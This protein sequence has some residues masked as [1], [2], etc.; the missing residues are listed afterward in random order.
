M[1]LDEIVA[2]VDAGRAVRWANGGYHVIRG[3]TG[4]LLIWCEFNDNCI[5]LTWQD[6]VTL[7]GR[8]EQFYIEDC[9]RR[10]ETA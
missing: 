3:A 5:G 10:K 4:E 1:T 2:A 9:P 7:N 8:P 6:G